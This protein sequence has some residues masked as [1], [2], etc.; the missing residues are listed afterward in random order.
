MLWKI[1]ARAMEVGRLSSNPD[2]TTYSLTLP[3]YA[4]VASSENG[5]TVI[6]VTHMKKKLRM[7]PETE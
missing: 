2:S 7:V 5:I 1:K 6:T 4:S 3:L